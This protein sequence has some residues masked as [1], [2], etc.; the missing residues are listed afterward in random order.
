MSKRMDSKFLS[1][2]PYAQEMDNIETMLFPTKIIGWLCF[3]MG[4][5]T[6][7]SSIILFVVGADFLDWQRICG[8]ILSCAFVVFV[9]VVVVMKLNE[10]KDK[11]IKHIAEGYG[12][13][14]INESTK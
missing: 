14:E 1:Q 13:G 9:C 8:V 7:V 6:I 10:E 12:F 4:V 11:Y 2:L 5:A 3:W